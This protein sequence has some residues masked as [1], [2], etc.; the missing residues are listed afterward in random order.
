MCCQA[1]GQGHCALPIHLLKEEAPGCVVPS[2][3]EAALERT[4]KE[5]TGVLERISHE[6][7]VFLPSL[8]TAEIIAARLGKLSSM[9]A[10]YPPIDFVKRSPGERTGQVLAATQTALEKAVSSRVLVITGGQVW[11][12]NVW[13]MLF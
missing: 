1:T 9:P 11:E 4:L 13:S 8:K 2:V 10:N 7:L 5:R 6:E 3:L 12:N